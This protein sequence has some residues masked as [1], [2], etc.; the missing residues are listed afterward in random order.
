MSALLAPQH[1]TVFTMALR[2]FQ[3][4][5]SKGLL[6]HE[7]QRLLMRLWRG[8]LEVIYYFCYSVLFNVSP[9]MADCK[10]C[11]CLAVHDPSG[12]TGYGA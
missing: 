3:T 8:S 10:N 4:L 6:T 1:F 12:I 5:A 9:R 7:L 11:V 2:I